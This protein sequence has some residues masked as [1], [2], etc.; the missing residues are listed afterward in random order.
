MLTI[1]RSCWSEPKNN[2]MLSEKN[3]PRINIITA[4]KPPRIKAF[5]KAEFAFSWFPA[6]RKAEY[7][8]A[9]PIPII[10]PSPFISENAGKARFSAVSP[11]L[12]TPLAT[13]NVSAKI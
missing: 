3:I 7:N 8:V 5:V 10:S 11:S 4:K 2:A 9:A 12:P 13:N 6:P 1:G